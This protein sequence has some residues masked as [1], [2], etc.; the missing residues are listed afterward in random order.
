MHVL[1]NTNQL[2][3]DGVLSADQ[4]RTLEARAREAMVLL[5]VNVLLCS[6]IVAAAGGTIFWLHDALLVALTGGVLAVLGALILTGLH[7]TWRIFGLAAALIGTGLL[8]GGGTVK[9][10]ADFN[11]MA[12]AVLTP[13]GLV[14]AGLAGMAHLSQSARLRFVTGAVFL[15]GM[16]VHLFGLTLL[17]QQHDFFGLPMP[18]FHLYFTAALIGAGWFS[19]LRFVTALAIVPFAQ[20]LDTGTFYGHAMYAFYSPESTLTILTLVVLIGAA[21]FVARRTDERTARHAGILAVMAF[22][23]ANLCALVGSLWGDVVGETVWGPGNYW[24]DA[25]FADYD[26][27]WA[28][29]EAFEATALT[30]S[31]G[32]YSLIWAAALAVLIVWAAQTNRRGLFNAGLTFAGIHGYTQVLENAGGEPMV[33]ALCGFAAIPLAWGAWRLNKWLAQRDAGTA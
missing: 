1:A 11:E 17:G 14:I 3:A 26:A 32:V 16:A 6:G 20:L 9:L 28:A 22:I 27:W 4:A 12:G 29:R 33:F 21:L 30:I 7:E 24:R 25:N 19:N 18:L 2:V 8:I 10:L 5:A 23:V 31:D 15:L 13:G